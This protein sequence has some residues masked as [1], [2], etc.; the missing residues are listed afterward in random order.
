MSVMHGGPEAIGNLPPDQRARVLPALT[1]AFHVVFWIAAAISL[2]ALALAL[3]LKEI[4]LRTTVGPRPAT[5]AAPVE[6]QV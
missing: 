1:H 5:A 4:P 2:V 6:R 3:R